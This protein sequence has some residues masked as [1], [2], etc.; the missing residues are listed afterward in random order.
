MLER[1]DDA[2]LI[3]SSFTAQAVYQPLLRAIDDQYAQRGMPLHP[4][5]ARAIA[6]M[7]TYT[8]DSD[9][10]GEANYRLEDSRWFQTLC[11]TLACNES[12][13]RKAPDEIAVR[14]L[15]DALVFDAVMLG[16]ALIRPRF[17]TNLGDRT[18]RVQYANRLLSWMA[19]AGEPDLAY[20][21]LPL[22]LAGVVINPMVAPSRD[23]PWLILEALREAYRGRV[24]LVAGHTV[25]IF[26]ML[27]RLLDA[28]EA[29]LRH[30]RLQRA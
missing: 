16:F 22:V 10:Y 29:D 30:A 1:F 8:L 14:F 11:Q 6:K 13:G 2:R 28:A 15:F 12:V 18:E 19:G 3:A 7:L 9:S 5:E 21:Y 27:D 17:R 25:E 23:D 4:G 20:I 24:R 26:D